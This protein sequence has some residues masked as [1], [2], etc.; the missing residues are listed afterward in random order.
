MFFEL[1]DSLVLKIMFAMENQECISVLDA[2]RLE[3]I[4]AEDDVDQENFYTLPL[5]SSGDGFNLLESFVDQLDKGSVREEL[6]KVLSAGR[7]VFRNFK[8]V[9]KKYPE[10]ERRWS[11]F[12]NKQMRL[13][14]M[15][16]YNTLRES[17]GLEK[18]NQETDDYSDLIKED[19]TFRGYDPVRDGDCI[20]QGADVIA[21]ELR[22]L[23][24]D[25]PGYALSQLWLEQCS[26]SVNGYVCRTLSDEFSGCLMYNQLS[27]LAKDSVFLT[28]CFVLQNYRGLGIAS[29][30]FSNCI[31][32]L[33]KSGVHWVIIAN[34]FVP[35]YLEPLLARMGF[36][37]TG[38]IFVADL[39]KN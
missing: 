30:L 6:K 11:L 15:D 29:Q 33:R 38:S 16:W 28:A 18:L 37:K 8:N 39:F 19:F 31:S 3:I 26:G 35:E 32:D 24:P 13:R 1:T 14:I 23:E 12:K 25:R 36:E 5:W 34:S 21:D 7:G 22:A 4:A 10:I 9:I 20:A 17:W 27:S 2:S